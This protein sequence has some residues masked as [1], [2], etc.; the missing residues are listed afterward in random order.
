MSKAIKKIGNAVSGVVK[1]VVKAVTSVVKAVVS[2][3]SSLVNMVVS[4]FMGD[5]GA[6]DIPSQSE[7]IKGVLVTKQGSNVTVPV[8]YGFR[9]VGSIITFAETGS[10]NNKYLWVA[11]VFSEGPVH[12]M[13]SLFIN[14]IQISG[15]VVSALN[16]GGVVAV[17]DGSKF[18]N[19]TVL[20]FFKGE[21]YSNT[22]S[23]TVGSAAKADIFSESPSWTTDMHYNGLSVLLARY[24]WK[25]AT[26][27][28]EADNNPFT[29]GIPTVRASIQGRKVAPLTLTGFSSSDVPTGTSGIEAYTYAGS[30]YT[31][32]WSANP[33]EIMLDYLRNPRY[34]K[35]LVN[36]DIDWDS[37]Y[38]AAHKCNQNV[39]YITGVFGPA[40]TLNYVLET[41]NT[42][43]NNV[44]LILQNMRAYLPYNRGKFY[45]RIED[46]GNATDITSGVA[47]IAKTFTKDNIFGNITYTGIDKTSKYNHVVVK[48]VDPDNKWTEQSIVYPRTEAERQTFITTDGGRENK[49]E[50]TFAGITNYAIACIFPLNFAA[51]WGKFNI[52]QD[53][54]YHERS[55]GTM[56]FFT[57][58]QLILPH[59]FKFFCE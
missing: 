15:G 49:G 40:L 11:Y 35:G 16:N 37:F 19:R 54:T 23:S 13:Q 57:T 8:I 18:A 14:D 28:S 56:G 30:G 47:T 5:F 1:G 36:A 25:E 41:G 55:H 44:K 9:E 52:H 46:A 2:V 20:Q 4:P 58:K 45:L 38:I 6:P 26:T 42:V 21:Y 22:T 50:F 29:G 32:R 3:A 7:S 39:E 34:G 53:I 27:Q 48:Y 51:V 10:S 33:A 17:N 59:Q 43:F 12:Q 31:E 24:E